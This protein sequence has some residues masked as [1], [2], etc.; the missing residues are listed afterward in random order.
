M[1]LSEINE[2]VY[3]LAD[4]GMLGAGNP[5]SYAVF[6]GTP[7]HRTDSNRITIHCS[8]RLSLKESYRTVGLRLLG[9]G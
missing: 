1:K 6:S 5:H 7:R 3:L 9:Y 8:G 2:I 4:Q